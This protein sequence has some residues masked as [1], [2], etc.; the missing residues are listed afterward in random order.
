MGKDHERRQP[1][2]ETAHP[3]R[4]LGGGESQQDDTPGHYRR[5]RSHRTQA[6]NDEDQRGRSRAEM[7]D[8][9]NECMGGIEGDTP[10]LGERKL[11]KV[12]EAL[13]AAAGS[14]LRAG[15]R[16]AA[17]NGREVRAHP[18]A[19]QDLQDEY[20]ESSGRPGLQRGYG[21]WRFGSALVPK[22]SWVVRL[23]S[24]LSQKFFER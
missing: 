10:G 9:L 20:A 12:P 24:L 7:M 6:E 2:R 18:G 15:E 22:T 8:P 1:G 19:E 23:T 3:E 4:D 16:S 11:A 17:G 21:W 14:L 5:P 13:K